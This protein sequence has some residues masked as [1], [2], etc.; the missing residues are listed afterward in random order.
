MKRGVPA[1]TNVA[2]A[3]VAGHSTEAEHAYIRSYTHVEYTRY[4]SSTVPICPSLTFSNRVLVQN[5]PSLPN[6]PQIVSKP[7]CMCNSV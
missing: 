1:G 6:P 5:L 2:P 4:T 3:A 7:V